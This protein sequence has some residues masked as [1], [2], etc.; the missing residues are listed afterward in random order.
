[1]QYHKPSWSQEQQDRLCLLMAEGKAI[2][3]Y[4]CSDQHGRPANGGSGTI[5][6]VGLIE[7]IPGPLAICTKKAL[8]GTH[9][10]HKWMGCRVW[11]IA[12]HGEVQTDGDKFGS[13]K[14]E[15]L[16]E[17]LPEEALNP[18]V[19]VRLGRKDL[20]GANLSWSDLSGSN[21]SEANLSRCSR[22]SD[23]PIIPG[24]KCQNGILV[25]E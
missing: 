13:L 17:I 14:R 22:Y 5:A 8:H 10:P 1:M 25:K 20:S 24:W 21:L 6:R 23:D 16:G 18:S 15:F 7:E 3:A 11:M 12:L 9:L 2:I 19:G 4:W